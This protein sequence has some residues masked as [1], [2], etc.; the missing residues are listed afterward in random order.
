MVA[1][2]YLAWPIVFGRESTLPFE[3]ISPLKPKQSNWVNAKVGLLK[4]LLACIPNGD[5]A[6]LNSSILISFFA[7]KIPPFDYNGFIK[8][9]LNVYI[10]LI[11]IFHSLRILRTA[12]YRLVLV[13]LE[14]YLAI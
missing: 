9:I 13:E 2:Q 6:F 8:K 4:Y 11:S 1:A 5:L 14:M 7:R 10:E 12:P 3:T